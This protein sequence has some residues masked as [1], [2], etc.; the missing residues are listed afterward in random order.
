LRPLRLQ[1]YLA[2]DA[3]G[4][5]TSAI[6][7]PSEKRKLYSLLDAPLAIDIAFRKVTAARG[8]MRNALLPGDIIAD[9]GAGPHD[10]LREQQNVWYRVNR[11]APEPGEEAV[12]SVRVQAVTE[13]SWKHR[14]IMGYIGHTVICDPLGRAAVFVAKEVKPPYFELMRDANSSREMKRIAGSLAM[15]ALHLRFW[16]GAEPG[17]EVDKALANEAGAVAR[18]VRKTRYELGPG[19]LSTLCV[20]I[21]RQDDPDGWWPK[22]AQHIAHHGLEE[23]FPAA[24]TLM[25]MERPHW[26]TATIMEVDA[27]LE[28][29]GW[30]EWNTEDPPFILKPHPIHDPKKRA[31]RAPHVGTSK[32]GRPRLHR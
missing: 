9:W 31:K 19:S 30:K 8:R 18:M 6:E 10:V 22:L 2:R 26:A 3:A 12:N 29:A 11:K 7:D 5:E 32:R 15:K 21:Y 14:R 1:R 20:R 27:I 17:T 16:D 24:R 13:R 4:Y 23:Q 28:L 25:A